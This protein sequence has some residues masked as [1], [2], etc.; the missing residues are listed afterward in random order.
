MNNK[1]LRLALSEI[2]N[3]TLANGSLSELWK[4]LPDYVAGP[5]WVG[6]I[7]DA[8]DQLAGYVYGD[9]ETSEDK[10]SDYVHEL[11][12]SECETYYSVIN[13]RVQDLSLWAYTELDYEVAELTGNQFD[14]TLTGL[15]SIY[16]YA[17]MRELYSAIA[18]HITNRANELEELESE[19]TNA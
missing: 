5:N 12:N 9:D 18:A 6:E 15:N 14:G 8:A 2:T 17:A 4:L 1:D 11:A 7:V 16:L 3:E 10:L 13:K 19:L